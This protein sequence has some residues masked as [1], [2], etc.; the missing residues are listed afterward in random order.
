MQADSKIGI[1]MLGFYWHINPNT[2]GGFVISGKADN[3][4]EVGAT[5]QLNYYLYSGSYIKYLEQFGSGFFYRI[6]AG[7]AKGILVFN[8][9]YYNES[10]SSDNGFG[11][12]IGGGYSFDFKHTRLLVGLNHSIMSIESDN[13][14]YTNLMISGL[15]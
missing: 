9:P 7:I 10:E 11:V 12:L 6:D 15:F 13:V 1:D 3:I 14:S 4:E 5:L 8:S 2:L